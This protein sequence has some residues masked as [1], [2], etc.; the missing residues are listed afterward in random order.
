MN[1]LSRIDGTSPTYAQMA[2]SGTV[3][4][5]LL[6]FTEGVILDQMVQSGTFWCLK[7]GTLTL[8]TGSP[9]TLAGSWT[10]SGCTP[11]TISLTKQ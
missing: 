2:V 3:S 11:G 8:T 1:G 10:A 4:G 7:T 9:D 6:T 5:S